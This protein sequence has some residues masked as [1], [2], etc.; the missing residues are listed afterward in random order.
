[1]WHYNYSPSP[2]EL[3]HYGVKGMKWKKRTKQFAKGAKQY[4]KGLRD[5]VQ[6]K[7]ADVKSDYYINKASKIDRK[8]M[9]GKGGKSTDSLK[10]V[11]KSVANT[12]KSYG[13]AVTG[14]KRL[15]SG[16]YNMKRALGITTA[17]KRAR[18]KKRSK[19]K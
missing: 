4:A 14:I 13:N 15:N 8:R 1:M 18:K 11:G 19:K 5:A 6:S 2:D 17:Q 9:R 10:A 3:Y 12:V 7:A 16:S